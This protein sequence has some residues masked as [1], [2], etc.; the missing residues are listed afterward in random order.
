MDFFRY[1]QKA[2]FLPLI[3]PDPAEAAKAAEFFVSHGLTCVEVPLRSDSALETVAAL[4]MRISGLR[5]AAGTVLNGKA[6][7]AAVEA[8]ADA[9]ISPGWSQEVFREAERRG[10]PYLP[11]VFTATEVQN[12]LAFGC[13]YLKFFPAAAAGV[14]YLKALSAAFFAAGVRFMPTGG[15]N[16]NNYRSFLELPSVF[17]V[18][19]SDFKS[20]FLKDDGE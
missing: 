14:G 16:H 1:L 4:K 10:V 18:S 8:G 6:A 17:C 13:R 20:V 11:G 19:G 12:A 3:P 7:A 5:T 9:L 15:I 2:E